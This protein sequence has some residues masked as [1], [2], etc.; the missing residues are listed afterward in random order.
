MRL[1]NLIKGDIWFQ[2]KYGFYTVY[3]IITLLYI[4]LLYAIPESARGTVAII[5]I[6]SDPAAMGLFFMGAVILLEKSQR[7][8]NSIAVSPVRVTE[9]IISKALTLGIIATV[10]GVL[11]STAAGQYHFIEAVIGT[12]LGS[13]IFSMIGLVVA[14]RIG[15]LSQFLIATIPFEL[16]CFAPPMI[17]LFGYDNPL[18]LLH[19]GCVVVS[20][21]SGDNGYQLLPILILVG[22]IILL[23]LMTCRVIGRMLQSV[24]GVKL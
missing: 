13:I 6:Y 4:L 14:A 22:W 24:G 8:V 11:I 10:V 16:L 17:Y 20:M 3:S 2:V 15:S 23:Y 18:M 7:V 1:K 12:F 19:P 5:L 21:L 9:Y